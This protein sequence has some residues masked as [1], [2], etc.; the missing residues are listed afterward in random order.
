M[1]LL[2]AVA[3]SAFGP[4]FISSRT[5]RSL[6][7][8]VIDQGRIGYGAS[9]RNGGFVMSW[10]PKIASLVGIAGEADG[11]WLADR[12]TA[13]IG[14]MA[15]FLADN[16]IDA[17]FVLGGWLWTATSPA[18]FGAWADVLKVA[19]G[20]GRPEVFE[21]VDSGDLARRTGSSLHLRGIYER[22]NGKVHPGKLGHGLGVIAKRLGVEL[23][24]DTRVERIDHGP[25][26]RLRTSRGT[27]TAPKLVIATNAWAREIAEVQRSVVCVS[28][29]IIATAPIPEELQKIGWTDG[30]TI[31]NS[32]STLNYYRTTRSGQIVFGKGWAKLQY[33]A[34]VAA[35]VFLD[36]DGI[37]AAKADFNRMYPGLASVPIDYGWSGPIDRTY[38]GLPIISSLKDQPHIAFGVGWS[39]NGVGPSRIGGQILAS[40]AAG[41]KDR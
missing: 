12:T 37:S 24:E 27:I 41:A 38:D 36:R 22:V 3:S 31:T 6:R 20:L 7:V 30:E 26:V 34:R 1:L 10:W 8:A 32:Q 21:E 16:G 13:S 9:G 19:R 11:L 5:I 23:Y 4:Q 40:I 35:E 18:H 2:P 28:S 15:D 17:E 39:G 29:A 25:P 33:G 14:E